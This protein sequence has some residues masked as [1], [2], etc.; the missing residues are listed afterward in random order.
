MPLLQPELG[1]LELVR[2]GLHLERAGR[3]VVGLGRGVGLD[4]G[5]AP[6]HHLVLVCCLHLALG[7]ERLAGLGLLLAPD[8]L[9][10]ARLRLLL[11]DSHLGRAALDVPVPLH[12][13]GLLPHHVPLALLC[14]P[15][16][17][18]LPLTQSGLLRHQRLHL[19]RR[20]L[21]P[22]LHVGLA[23]P[24]GL[25]ALL[26]RALSRCELRCGAVE[27]RLLVHELAPRLGLGL[28]I[29]GCLRVRR[30]GPKG[31]RDHL[32]SLRDHLTEAGGVWRLCRRL[33]ERV[34]AWWRLGLGLRGADRLTGRRHFWLVGLQLLLR[35]EPNLLDVQR[36]LDGAFWP[37]CCRLGLSRHRIVLAAAV[38]A[39][40]AVWLVTLQLGCLA[41]AREVLAS[42]SAT[43]GGSDS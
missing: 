25:L 17:P 27:A 37:V 15:L 40:E 5:R 14:R 9:T 19:L 36:H 26:Q 6:G 33:G 22:D 3:H 16:H 12:Q 20:L 43:E 35:V 30:V 11:P 29:T 39:G 23:A 41:R 42:P 13:S 38:V 18:R 21:D 31:L 10:L 2:L 34:S 24:H 7:H 1:V 32:H 4:V 8:H 28:C